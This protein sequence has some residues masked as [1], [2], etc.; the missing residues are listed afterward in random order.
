MDIKNSPL[1]IKKTRIG[2]HY[3]P[4]TLHYRESDLQTWLPELSALGA[5]WLVLQS[6]TNRAIPEFFLRNIIEEGIEPIIQ[7]DLPV[8]NPPD[9]ASLRSLLN[10]YARWGTRAVLWFDRPNARS[11]W[12]AYGWAQDDLVERFLD[13]YVPLAA[14]TLEM[15]MTPVM[16]PL[17]PGGSYWDTAFLRSTLE[18]LERRNQAQ[19]LQKLVLS[20]YAWTWGHSLNW[21]AGGPARWPD[22]RPYLEQP[23]QQDQRGFR[24]F[25][26]YNTITQAVLGQTCPIL[27][28]GAGASR[29]PFQQAAPAIETEKHQHT[30]EAI[31]SLLAG[32]PTVD[33]CDGTQL[34]PVP[35]EVLAC[36]F[37]LLAA[38]SNSPYDTQSWYRD[39]GS[40]VQ[41]VD[42]MKSW[43][44][45]SRKPR[46]RWQH[47]HIHTLEATK[48]REPQSGS[49]P[50]RHYLLLPTFEFGVADWHLNII[51]PYMKK[52]RPTVGFSLAEA[53]MASRVT[54]L[55]DAQAI[56]EE[57][58]DKLRQAGSFVERISGDGTSIASILAER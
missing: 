23:T 1:P 46:A 20:A 19:L 49:H 44:S 2:F 25:D 27:L 11:S 36:N 16:P 42:S 22:A 12:P 9:A 37:W 18:A 34:D 45:K 53:A 15:G 3:Y 35:A 32:E 30:I 7:F 28:L 39:D 55:G 47:S 14:A 51:R 40:H 56:P 21:G 6:P 10:V 54:V 13:R 50:I 5:S 4:D 26:W 43:V 8:Y 29:D 33:P 31:T 52:F 57:A 58:L 41:A 17:E 38:G 48:S 24:V